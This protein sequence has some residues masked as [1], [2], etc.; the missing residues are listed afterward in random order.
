MFTR[1]V[2]EFHVIWV[3]TRVIIRREGLME[4]LRVLG[5]A[6]CI[7][8]VRSLWNTLRNYQQE[9][10][11]MGSKV[12]LDTSRGHVD[13][14]LYNW[15]CHEPGFT[16]VMMQEIREGITVVDI[17]ANIGYYALLES[18]LV[19]KTGRVYAIEPAPDNFKRLRANIALN[20]Y[21][22]IEVFQLA[23]GNKNGKEKLYLSASP[24][25]HNLLGIEGKTGKSKTYIGAIDIETVTLDEF[26]KDKK[27]PDLVRMDVEGY[28][29]H[30]TEGMKKT[31]GEARNLAVFMELHLSTMKTAGLN[32]A[33]MF[34][35]FYHAGFE[36]KYLIK[37]HLMFPYQNP[38]A[39]SPAIIRLKEK[40]TLEKL[41]SKIGIIGGILMAKGASS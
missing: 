32:I 5:R 28:E 20:N 38:Y 36:P 15:G 27:P 33:E 3:R 30:I 14:N 37:R 18:R 10:L 24:N 17:G 13:F 8:L 7:K 22:N 29:Y 40:W 21:A 34:E 23:V 26:L 41:M 4:Y 25:L 35:T 1:L 12:N 11:I 16:Y 39:E 2:G 9:K 31:L 19:G 6:P